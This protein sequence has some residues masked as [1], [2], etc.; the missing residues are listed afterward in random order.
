MRRL[1]YLAFGWVL[2][3][4][5]FFPAPPTVTVSPVPTQIAAPTFTPTAFGTIP[6]SIPKP[7]LA[8]S[9]TPN[10]KT[11]TPVSISLIKK[12]LITTDAE[13]GSARPEI[14]ATAT[15]VFVLY[16]GNIAAGS[17][18]TFSLKIYDNNVDR[19]IASKVL[20]STTPEYGGPTD[21][22][23][24]SD[25]QFLYAF[26]E[27]HKPTVP[28]TAMTYLWGAKYALD[29]RFDRVAYTSAPIA[30]S[31]PLS[32]LGN[33]GELLDDPAPLIGPD[34][35][36]VVTRLKYSLSMSGK[37]IY[38]V[39]EF[40]KHDLT[41]LTQFDLDLSDA[42]DGRARVAS[43]LFWNNS[44]LM[45]LPTTVSDRGINEN[46]DDGALS[47][48][49]LVR[50]RQ[51]WTFDPQK[52]VKTLSAE[53]NDRENYVSGFKTDGKYFYITFK[54]ATGNPPSGEQVAWI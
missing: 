41:K 11:K 15:R 42:T 10:G 36:F 51:N 3:A 1:L 24:A 20:V 39:R 12:V 7:T 13:G 45:A 26:Y 27:T 43:L 28:A 8:G 53:T 21:I 44:I 46:V 37:T 31:R 30:S 19:M 32:E 52:D 16:L 35:V 23:V 38:R 34:S 49:L 17:N 9:P 18:R 25:G 5:N 54:Q 22:R 2:V 40:S 6:A 47:D 50:I 14:A 29:D 4:C 33:G 48:I